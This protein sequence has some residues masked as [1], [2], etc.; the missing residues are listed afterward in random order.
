MPA[1]SEPERL[2][3]PRQ[4]ID[5]SGG[6]SGVWVA[7]QLRGRARFVAIQTGAAV[8]DL[9]EV[10]SG[11]AASDKLIVG[12]RDGLTDGA[13]VRVVGEDESLGIAAPPPPPPGRKKK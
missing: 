13:R 5:T 8:G 12:G 6:R 1:E 3:V 2:F 10:V 7:D 9:V 4:L 11:L